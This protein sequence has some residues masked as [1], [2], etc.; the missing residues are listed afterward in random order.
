[1]LWHTLRRHHQVLTLNRSH[2]DLRSHRSIRRA[3]AG[4]RFDHA[5]LTAAMSDVDA[6]ESQP[7]LARRI[8]AEAPGWI[9]THC[10]QIGA[11]LTFLSTD[12]VFPGNS[13]TPLDESTP[14]DPVNAYG[15]SKLAGEQS[16]I[17]ASDHHLVARVSWLFGGKR[18]SFPEW[19]VCQAAAQNPIPLAADKFAS[20]TYIPDLAQWISKLISLPNPP[21]GIL[22]LCNS[23]S[24]SSA[25]WGH[26]CAKLA[27][28]CGMLATTPNI[29]PTPSRQIRTLSAQRPQHTVLDTRRFQCISHTRPRHWNS[30]LYDFFRQFSLAKS[31]YYSNFKPQT[32]HH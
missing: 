32:I 23:G 4:L 3:L 8:N 26:A 5:I 18:P 14:T 30:A 9:A 20:P 31:D 25:D 6:C 2:I 7:L 28:A 11:R 29:I 27:V 17:N 24:C 21:H 12:F 1:M 22:H 16:V 10:A 15:H 13:P 19:L